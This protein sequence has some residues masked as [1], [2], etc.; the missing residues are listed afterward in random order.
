MHAYNGLRAFLSGRYPADFSQ[1]RRCYCE[2]HG[3]CPQVK[4]VEAVAQQ[5]R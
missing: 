3:T 5:A 1:G 4:P 2:N